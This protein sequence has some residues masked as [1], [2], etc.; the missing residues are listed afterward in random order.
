MNSDL[1]HPA[2]KWFAEHNTCLSIVAK[3]LEFRRAIFA[4]WWNFANTNLVAH[5]L[6]GFFTFDDFTEEGEEEEEK[7]E[8]IKACK[9]SEN[10]I[11]DT[12]WMLLKKWRQL[13]LRGECK[14]KRVWERIISWYLLGKLSFDTTDVLL[15]YLTVSYLVLHL[16]RLFR[17]TTE[18]QQPRRKAIQPMY[19]PQ[20]LQVVFFGENK[21]HSVVT[22]TAAWMN[23]SVIY[24]NEMKW[25]GRQTQ[26]TND[27][28]MIRISFFFSFSF[29]CLVGWL[30]FKE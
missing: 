6:D 17:T 22:I 13:G 28:I 15:L 30:V 1:M 16:S 4:L 29:Y 9:R 19:R 2:S 25:N 24:T 8:Q 14:G 18:Q 7:E 21:D 11:Q 26:T 27:N 5:H 23:L 10:W 12:C 20:V 3:L